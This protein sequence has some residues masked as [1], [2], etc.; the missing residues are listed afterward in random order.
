[1]VNR[2]WNGSGKAELN[3]YGNI[4]SF[5]RPAARLADAWIQGDGDLVVRCGE[6]NTD[7]SS[8]GIVRF[9]GNDRPDMLHIVSRYPETELGT[10]MNNMIIQNYAVQKL[11]LSNRSSAWMLPLFYVF[12]GTKL[13][14]EQLQDLVGIRFDVQG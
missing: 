12:S 2:I 5:V 6:A 8:K 14:Y 13:K 7:V 4:I 11:R 10:Y 3:F 1:V 9:G